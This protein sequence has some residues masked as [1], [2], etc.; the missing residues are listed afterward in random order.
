MIYKTIIWQKTR[1]ITIK[2]D[3]ETGAM[4]VLVRRED[5]SK[6]K[7]VNDNENITKQ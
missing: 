6:E 4:E 5:E 3:I 1:N 2:D 7:I